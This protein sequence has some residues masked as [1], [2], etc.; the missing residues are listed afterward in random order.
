MNFFSR[1][2][3]KLKFFGISVFKYK[4]YEYNLQLCI[5]GIKVFKYELVDNFFIFYIFGIPFRKKNNLSEIARKV[6]IQKN[7]F[8]KAIDKEIENIV[9]KNNKQNNSLFKSNESK[10][11]YINNKVAYLATEIYD[12]GGHTKC[13]RDLI[14]SLDGDFSQAIFLTQLATSSKLGAESLN[15][16]K[17]YSSVYG[18]NTTILFLKKDSI[19]I[20]KKIIEFSPKVLFSYIHPNDIVGAGILAYIHFN[21]NIK[22]IFFNHASHFPCLGM[23]FSDLILEG[24]ITN[25]RITEEQRGFSNCQVIGLQSLSK[26]ETIYYSLKDISLLKCKYNYYDAKYVTMSGGTAYKFFDSEGNSNYFLMI[27]EL[28]QSEPCLKHVVISNFNNKQILIIKKIFNNNDCY[29]RLIFIPLQ[30][31]FDIFFQSSDVFIDSFPISSA[32]TQIDLMRNKVASVVKIN[33]K[34]PEY[35]FHDYQK[36]GY[37]FMFENVGDMKLAILDLLHDA[38][39]R[40]RVVENNYLYWLNT[41][42]KDVVKSKYVNI[43]NN[44]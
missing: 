35:S 17:K 41:Y 3:Y 11:I 20:A 37:E 25:K 30:K 23:S 42:E 40:K 13:L 31:K 10:D 38:E 18:K 1:N 29:K 33:K 15:I 6:K 32:L 9:L 34:N 7:F 22:T 44:I 5:L 24:T 16:I 39:K 14:A 19:S 26:R 36:N 27:K 2:E 21:S 4:L 28:L 8:V 43:I 12:T